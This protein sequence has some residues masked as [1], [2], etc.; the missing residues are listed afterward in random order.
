M[1]ELKRNVYIRM[2]TEQDDQTFDTEAAG[3]VWLKGRQIII[4]Y[5]ET[6]PDLHGVTTM[7]RCS[8]EEISLIRQG[9]IRM[10]QR[11]V[12]GQRT[13]GTYEIAQ[14]Q[15]SMVTVTEQLDTLFNPQGL[16]RAVW[17]YRLWLGGSEV[18]YF[19]ITLDVQEGL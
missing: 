6:N 18:G 4:R 3:V 16:G 1:N 5:E 7:V 2:K 9:K 14:G 11:F 15:L 8:G 13:S 12:L 19:R 17:A 10:N